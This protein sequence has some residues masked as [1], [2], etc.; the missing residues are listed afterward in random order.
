MI[1]VQFAYFFWAFADWR[2]SKKTAV[3]CSVQEK[4]TGM[5]FGQKITG[6]VA[7]LDRG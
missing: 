6:C 1:L 2:E 5:D 7:R 3:V 4:S